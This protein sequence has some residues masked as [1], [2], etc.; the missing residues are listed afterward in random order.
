MAS[1]DEFLR[2]VLDRGGSD[3]HIIAGDPARIRLHGDLQTLRPGGLKVDFVRDAMYEIMTKR[4]V[5]RFESQ[6]GAD[7]AYTLPGAGRF[8]VNVLRHLRG[9]GGVFRAIPSTA[10]TLDQLKAP[11][12]IRQYPA[13][14]SDNLFAFVPTEKPSR[15][16]V[17][18]TVVLIVPTA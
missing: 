10:L 18:P 12:P 17:M 15:Y 16:R 11:Q 3:L 9:V 8:R 4:A 13:K 5:E 1:I 2:E 6:D 14:L 7:F